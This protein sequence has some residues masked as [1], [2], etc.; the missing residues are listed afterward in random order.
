MTQLDDY[1]SKLA[2]QCDLERD[3]LKKIWTKMSTSNC[4]KRDKSHGILDKRDWNSRQTQI[5]WDSLFQKQI[6]SILP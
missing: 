4:R 6:L 1:S 3:N 5:R 2:K